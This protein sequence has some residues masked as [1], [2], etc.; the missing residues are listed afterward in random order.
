MAKARAPDSFSIVASNFYQLSG[1]TDVDQVFESSVYE[2]TLAVG[3]AVL[4]SSLNAESSL[5][6]ACAAWL[7]APLLE[8][9][10]T[11]TNLPSFPK[12]FAM[13]QECLSCNKDPILRFIMEISAR[14]IR[15]GQLY[16]LDRFSPVTRYHSL[17][18]SFSLIVVQSV[19]S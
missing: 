10:S 4:W 6:V 5:E 15:Y 17:I 7:G 12:T 11:A 14:S 1:P 9:T 16:S 18:F 3:T 8:P 2:L 19:R 13:V